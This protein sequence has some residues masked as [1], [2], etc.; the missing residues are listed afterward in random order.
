[1]DGAVQ[2]SSPRSH[3]NLS[4]AFQPCGSHCC[5]TNSQT[6]CGSLPQVHDEWLSFL[7][8]VGSV[9]SSAVNAP[10]ALV[11][12]EALPALP[13]TAPPVGGRG[14]LT[15]R[16]QLWRPPQSRAPALSPGHAAAGESLHGQGKSP[17]ARAGELAATAATHQDALPFSTAS[18]HSRHPMS[19]SCPVPVLEKTATRA[20]FLP[21]APCGASRASPALRLLEPR[22]LPWALGSLPQA[23]DTMYFL[24]IYQS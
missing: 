10:V 24:G 18:F 15:W 20:E 16:S 11:F 19:V 22:L 4:A 17:R 3:T 13:R 5:V 6:P 1:M 14:F 21:P 23:S 12:Q 8:L 7:G 9:A 2:R